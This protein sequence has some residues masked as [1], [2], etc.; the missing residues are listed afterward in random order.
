MAAGVSPA[1]GVVSSSAATDA[2]NHPDISNSRTEASMRFMAGSFVKWN[3]R[4]R[5]A[6][7]DG[8][9]LSPGSRGFSL[10][11]HV[12]PACQACVRKQ[13]TAYVFR[14]ENTLSLLV[15]GPMSRTKLLH[16]SSRNI[17]PL[18]PHRSPASSFAAMFPTQQPAFSDLTPSIQS[19]Y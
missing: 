9:Q 13:S 1:A 12:Q 19:C 6:N 5:S 7:P 14:K 10:A 3:R 17:A 2:V 18:D 8:F 11:I 15:H 16:Q 4:T